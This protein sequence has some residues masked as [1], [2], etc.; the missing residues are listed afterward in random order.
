MEV[1]LLLAIVKPV[2]LIK[3]NRI[4]QEVMHKSSRGRK[5]NA[6]HRQH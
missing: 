2:C 4:I 6:Y 5:N 1:G 3:S